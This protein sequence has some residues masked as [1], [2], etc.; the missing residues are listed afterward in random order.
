MERVAVAS[1]CV[2]GQQWGDEAKGKI[3]DWLCDAHD[4]VVRYQG[5]ANAGHTVVAN[6]VTY[7]LSLIPTGI[8]RPG[9][10][11]VIGNGV[12]VH[13]PAF[14]KEVETLVGQGVD[15]GGRL[16]VSDRAHVILPY[17]LAEERS[18]TG[19]PNANRAASE[20]E[21]DRTRQGK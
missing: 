16:H 9:I 13:P 21:T 8:L 19:S 17:H 1:T 11:C 18:T 7:K 12:V 10:G 3:V 14:L 5:G 20:G 6:G 2:V 4:V 15:V